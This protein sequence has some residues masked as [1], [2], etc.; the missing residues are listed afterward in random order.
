MKRCILTGFCRKAPAEAEGLRNNRFNDRNQLALSPG[1]VLQTLWCRDAAVGP[2]LAPSQSLSQIPQ[3]S[4][5][6]SLKHFPISYKSLSYV[7]RSFVSSPKMGVIGWVM[8]PWIWESPSQMAVLALVRFPLNRSLEN[9]I[10]GCCQT[11]IP[12]KIVLKGAHCIT[13]VEMGLQN[14]TLGWFVWEKKPFK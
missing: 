6:L 3:D 12:R 14:A 10:S 7:F 4:E 1:G 2:R 9:R 8:V 5:P 13:Q 11:G